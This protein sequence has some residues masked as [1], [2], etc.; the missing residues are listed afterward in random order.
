MQCIIIEKLLGFIGLKHTTGV[1]LIR[2]NLSSLFLR[3]T[4]NASIMNANTR[5]GVIHLTTN[6]LRLHE[7]I[8]TQV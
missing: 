7:T 5:T 3:C 1:M 6:T 8:P 2:S 4:C